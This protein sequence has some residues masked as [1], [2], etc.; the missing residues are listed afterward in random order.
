MHIFY[1][2]Q[3]LFAVLTVV[4]GLRET[5]FR[6]VDWINLG[7]LQVLTATSVETVVVILD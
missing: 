5:V 1:V 7:E 4:M 3:I 2:V 6:G